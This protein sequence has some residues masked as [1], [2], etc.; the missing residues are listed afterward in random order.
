M[1][2]QAQAHSGAGGST[3]TELA[4]VMPAVLLLVLLIV[5]FGLWL[6]ARQVAAAAAQEGL[7][8]T[9]VEHGSEEVGRRRTEEFLART[10]G[11]TEVTVDVERSPT[12]ARVEVAGLAPVV[13]PGVLLRARALVEGPVERF[14]AE[15]DR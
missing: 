14:V 7:A 9:Q 10:P 2:P 12:T 3:T 15:P 8:A 4:V 11:L 1:G 13:V 6:H 5:Q